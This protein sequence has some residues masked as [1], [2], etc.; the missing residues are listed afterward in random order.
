MF[1]VLALPDYSLWIG[2]TTRFTDGYQWSD[3]SPFGF[4]NWLEGEPNNY[5]S[6]LRRILILEIKIINN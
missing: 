1:K 6:E 4:M 5:W 3:G 2:A